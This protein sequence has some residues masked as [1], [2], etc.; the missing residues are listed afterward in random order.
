MSMES[1][2]AL[3]SVMAAINELKAAAEKGLQQQYQTPAKRP[4]E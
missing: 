3:F 2:R 1:S 4:V